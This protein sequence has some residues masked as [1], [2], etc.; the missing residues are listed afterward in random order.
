M[1]FLAPFYALGALAIGLP[2]LFH[3][4][5]RQPRGRTA[6]SS[7]L[8]LRPSPPTLTRRSRLDHWPLLLIRALA[9]MMLALA[10]SRPFLR[11]NE[12]ADVV[13]EARRV[14][15]L[16]DTSASMRRAGLWQQAIGHVEEVLAELS[17][18]DSL[19]IVEFNS[20]PD[21]LMGFDESARLTPQARLA[22]VR[23]II[24]AL[25]PTWRPTRFGP[26]FQLAA[27]LAGESSVV[28]TDAMI[29]ID[30]ELD[31]DSWDAVSSAGDPSAMKT[32]LVLISDLQ[33]GGNPEALRSFAWPET[34]RLSLRPVVPTASSNAYATILQQAEDVVGQ[35]DAEL[36]QRR[37]RVRVTNAAASQRADFTLSWDE[38]SGE[39][40]P[41]VSG[42]AAVVSE[43]VQ[44]PPGES[45]VVQMPRP[46]GSVRALILSGDDHD[47]DNVRYV[48]TPERLEMTVL[49]L[50]GEQDAQD[51]R[52][53]LF[54]Y[55]SRAP[56]SDASR[57]ITPRFVPLSEPLPQLAPDAVALLVI[58]DSHA[59][60]MMPEQLDQVTS[61]LRSGGRVVYVFDQV[62]EAAV[63]GGGLATL[64]D[65]IESDDTKRG[66]LK[67]VEAAVKDYAMWS[68]IDF[69][70]PLFSPLADPKFNDFSRIRF[71][72]H[73]S[74]E[75]VPE[76][77]KSLATFDDGSPALLE[78]M[79]GEG[80]LW[81]LTAGWHPRDGQLALS[82]KFVPLMVSFLDV[83]RRDESSLTDR[84]VGDPLPWPPSA[85][86]TVRRP[87]GEEVSYR[88][89]A[90]A[91]QIDAPGV[92]ELVDDAR[93][94]RFAV[95]LDPKE[96]LID[97][98]AD[99]QWEAMGVKLDGAA[100]AAS[101]ERALAHQR[102]LRD[103]ELESRQ[104]GWQWLLVA[105]LGLVGMETW[106]GG[107]LS[108][109]KGDAKDV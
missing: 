84:I 4:I 26:V 68:R 104:R 90:D 5:R 19:A 58:A 39:L 16:I 8:F 61:F 105:V 50:G 65:R 21:V 96:S 56:L 76:G 54:Y 37:T 69:G 44:V 29:P 72:A 7:L 22:A 11:S 97:R 81:V 3:L 94:W 53:S 80:R 40:P 6:V 41:K 109:T 14:M 13:E 70:H 102:Q 71:W 62:V 82:T 52:D 18:A 98:I 64:A 9:L 30:G 99:D 43:S 31:G 95:N 74:I 34:I 25:E 17:D 49:I 35:D 20:H 85:T 66:E 45:R 46:S 36:G 51:P 55:L 57:S 100:D 75:G 23:S 12:T 42:G 60:R 79:V 2:I 91:K 10:F 88:T 59:S 24:E 86:A 27:D 38:E 89:L 107:F 77:F 101:R 32:Q 103:V 108:R 83:G 87:T 1:S 92:Y 63:S 78:R 28:S 15:V 73:R 106:L 48:V 33:S 47:F 93:R 67:I